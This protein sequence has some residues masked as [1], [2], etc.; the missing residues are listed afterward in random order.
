[1]IAGFCIHIPSIPHAKSHTS[2]PPMA[3]QINF[4]GAFALTR[5]LTPELEKSAPSRVVTVSSV[6]HRRGTLRFGSAPF[7]TDYEKGTYA[8]AKL[9][10]ARG[11]PCSRCCML[12][13]SCS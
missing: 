8:H 4:L 2:P 1:M 7:L 5:L 13:P 3:A 10:E 11:R 12:P 9:A 6:M